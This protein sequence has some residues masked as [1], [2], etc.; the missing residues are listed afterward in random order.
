MVG[1]NGLVNG[2][3]WP[4]RQGVLRDG[5][6]GEVEAGIAG[7]TGKGAFSIV[8]ADGGYA[9]KDECDVSCVMNVLLDDHTNLHETIYYC[10]TESSTNTPT[11]GTV[12]LR[13]TLSHH[14]HPIRVLRAAKKKSFYAPDEGI[15][16]DG[17]YNIV[18]EEL[19]KPE[20][21]LYR[22]KLVRVPGQE[23]IRYK[24][25]EKRP[26]QQQIVEK[27]RT[28]STFANR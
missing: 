3:W 6:H 20:T 1:H 19:L 14:N 23:P 27:Q 12:L 8:M 26:T 11:K 22:F 10:S 2:Q 21:A 5:A 13:S 28:W 24:G 16:Y 15:R 4:I 17:L 25:P 9:D 7:K 18:S